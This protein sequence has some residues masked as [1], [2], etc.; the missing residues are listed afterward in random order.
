[1]DFKPTRDFFHR[2][3]CCHAPGQDGGRN[4]VAKN[5][6]LTETSAGVERY[7]VSFAL[8]P[9]PAGNSTAVE[10]DVLEKRL[11]NSFE[12]ALKITHI[13]KC[14]FV[15]FPAFFHEDCLTISRKLIRAERM[16][17]ANQL[18]GLLM[19]LAESFPAYARSDESVNTTN[20]KKVEKPQRHGVINLIELGVPNSRRA[21]SPV[22]DFEFVSP[23]PSPNAP[24]RY[25][26]QTRSLRH[27]VDSR[28]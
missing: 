19:H 9:P 12:H 1:M 26:R 13:P 8:G 18:P 27:C 17:V 11:D 21:M 15:M 10:F 28:L 3:V 25:T 23:H 16:R 20:F 14:D 4:A 22:F 2:T 6:R 5:N 7:Q 24:R